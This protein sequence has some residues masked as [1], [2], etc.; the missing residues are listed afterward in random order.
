MKFTEFVV[1]SV[2]NNRMT[3]YY[4]DTRKDADLAFDQACVKARK[5][6]LQADICMVGYAEGSGGQILR[7]TTIKCHR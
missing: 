5:K 2:S 7:Q 4:R 6:G 3:Q 1:F